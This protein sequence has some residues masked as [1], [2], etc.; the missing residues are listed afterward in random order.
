[1]AFLVIRT[2]P[3]IFFSLFYDFSDSPKDITFK[4]FINFVPKF[5]LKRNK[6]VILTRALEGGDR[7]WP[8]LMFFEDIKKTDGLIFMRFSVPD[9]K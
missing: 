8:P 3:R 4:V 2:F 9:Q 6:S 1:M 5:V 7:F